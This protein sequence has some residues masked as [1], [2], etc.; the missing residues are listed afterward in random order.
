MP[1]CPYCGSTAH[2]VL[3]NTQLVEDGW[4]ITAQR[5]YSCA[6]SC[7]FNTESFYHSNGYEEVV[8]AVE[9]TPTDTPLCP[10]CGSALVE[11]DCIDM[12]S[13]DAGF[14]GLCVGYCPS[15][16]TTYQWRKKYLFEGFDEVAECD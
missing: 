16:D 9:P 14:D 4:T 10:K 6:C 3:M 1:K 8:F 7:Q 13:T 2:P 11:D 15:C 5:K 12:I